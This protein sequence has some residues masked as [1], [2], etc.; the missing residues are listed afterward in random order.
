MKKSILILTFMVTMIA[1]MFGQWEVKQS[2][3]EF[4]DLTGDK[5]AV[6]VMEDG[7]FSNSATTNAKL[8]TVLFYTK[9]ESK[10]FVYFNLWEYHSSKAT[11]IKKGISVLK[12]KDNDGVIHNIKVYQ[13]DD[14]ISIEEESLNEFINL[15]KDNSKLK[16]YYQEL[17]EY[18]N[19]TY[20]FTINCMNF[21]KSYNEVESQ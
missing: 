13:L 14:F 4:G 11:F 8:A 9:I 12:L 6:V 2:K 19:S 1:N 18:S 17:G 5:Y 16:A 7:T 15:L 10:P 3:D 21:T 20:K